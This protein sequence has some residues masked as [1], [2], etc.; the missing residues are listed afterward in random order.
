[1]EF[2]GNEFI[3]LSKL[4]KEKINKIKKSEEDNKGEAPTINESKE[5]LDNS[6]QKINKP[7][8]QV[9]SDDSDDSYLSVNSNSF[10]ID[11]KIHN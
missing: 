10:N 8:L 4:K 9:D 1:M 11:L 5:T 3:Y 6:S 2:A 7:G